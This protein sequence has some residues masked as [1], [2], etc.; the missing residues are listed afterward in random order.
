MYIQNITNVPEPKK[1]CAQK[2]NHH[3]MF[4]MVLYQNIREGARLIVW[5]SAW[6]QIGKLRVWI[7]CIDYV[8]GLRVPISTPTRQSSVWSRGYRRGGG[9]PRPTSER[10][11]CRSAGGSPGRFGLHK[12]NA[13]T[14]ENPCAA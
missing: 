10:R 14:P 9:H 4:A 1:V 6:T 8:Y 2:R 3:Q 5:N 7:T 12:S 11:Q 13:R